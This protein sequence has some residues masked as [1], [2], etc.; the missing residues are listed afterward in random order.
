MLP[1]LRPC[2]CPPALEA[3]RGDTSGDTAGTRDRCADRERM[4]KKG[5]GREE[6][7]KGKGREE[8]EDKARGGWRGRTEVWGDLGL[9]GLHSA[10]AFRTNL[11]VSPLVYS[12]PGWGS[13]VHQ[14]TGWAPLSEDLSLCTVFLSIKGL[15]WRQW[16]PCE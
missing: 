6:V 7:R 1:G 15:C 14:E 2:R 9:S 8:G 11:S 13:E 3:K 4:E 12:V 10:W 16:P 5:K